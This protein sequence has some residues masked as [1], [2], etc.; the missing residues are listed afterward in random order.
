MHS[1]SLCHD[2]VPRQ[3]LMCTA[4]LPTHTV[5]PD[6]VLFQHMGLQATK[7]MTRRR[8]RSVP[9]SRAANFYDQ[10]LTTM[11]GVTKH[12]SCRTMQTGTSNAMQTNTQP[13]TTGPNKPDQQASA[14]HVKDT[15]HAKCCTLAVVIPPALL[16]QRKIDSSIKA[17]TLEHTSPQL[18]DGQPATSFSQICVLDQTAWCA[19]AMP[20][21]QPTLIKECTTTH[22]WLVP[23]PGALPR[24]A[25]TTA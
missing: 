16:K 18:K 21:L 24:K 11:S 6:Q 23:P 9:M 19:H 12:I 25:V 20:F 7:Q 3:N 14:S 8:A 5:K 13:R 4:P 2:I 1:R 22:P 10:T 17:G 15:L